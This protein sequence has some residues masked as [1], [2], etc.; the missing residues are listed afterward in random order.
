MALSAASDRA[1]CQQILAEGVL[2]ETSR[3]PLASR[4][5]LWAQLAKRAGFNDPF[6]ITPDLM[7]AV[8]G[9][10]KQAGYRSAY[11]YLEAA[12]AHHV[13][14][15]Y[16]WTPQLQQAKRGA[17][18]SCKRY[19]GNPKQAGGL[20]FTRLATICDT[21]PLAA[22]GPKWPGRCTILISWWLLREREAAQAKRGHITVD[23]ELRQITWRLPSSKTDQS[24]SA[25]TRA[26]VIS[27]LVLCAPFT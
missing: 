4:L 16:S 18:R 2:A 20:P 3:G 19:L 24:R 17:I 11:Q 8:M 10:L 23:H 12:H 25:A 22:M 1:K 14:L 21:E 15:G 13:S 5:S 26:P 27:H 6:H 9:A 7:F